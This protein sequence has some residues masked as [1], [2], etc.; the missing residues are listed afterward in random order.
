[1][2]VGLFYVCKEVADGRRHRHVVADDLRDYFESHFGTVTDAIVIGSQ[3]G[4]T[5]F[6][7]RGFGFVTF[8]HES[9][10]VAAVKEHYVV[11]LGKKVGFKIYKRPAI[12]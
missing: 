2:I 4:D 10:V 12:C 9:S 3:A 1:M 6:S 7:S 5:S 8:K 11:L